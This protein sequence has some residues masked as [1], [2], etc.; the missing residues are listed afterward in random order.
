MVNRITGTITASMITVALTRISRSAAAMGPCGSSAPACNT[1]G[2]I[3]GYLCPASRV[4]AV[5]HFGSA[6]KE[7]DIGNIEIAEFVCRAMEVEHRRGRVGAKACGTGLV[8]R[9]TERM[10]RHRRTGKPQPR[11]R[12]VRVFAT[13]PVH[14]QQSLGFVAP[15]GVPA[16]RHQDR[17]R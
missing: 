4:R 11:G 13:L 2:V 7:T 10:V 15:A 8:S 1:D 9:A 17:C 16:T 12:F 3:A 14:V 6:Y 5:H